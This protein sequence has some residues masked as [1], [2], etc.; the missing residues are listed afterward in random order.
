[1]C[2]DHR[3]LINKENH[4]DTL[5]SLSSNQHNRNC[6]VKISELLP[7]CRLRNIEASGGRRDFR[8]WFKVLPPFVK[9][10]K[11]IQT[12]RGILRKDTFLSIEDFDNYLGVTGSPVR[13]WV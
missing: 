4:I 3:N 2:E 12:D 9:V 13:G 6:R 7:G 8:K 11:D 10:D 1:V 5:F